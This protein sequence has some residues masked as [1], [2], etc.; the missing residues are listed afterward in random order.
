MRG[1]IYKDFSVFCKCMDKKMIAVAVGFTV[2]LMFSTGKYGGLIASILFAMLTGIQN[3]MSIAGDDKVHW[4]KY[5]MT[6]PLSGFSVVASKYI[7]VICT[8]GISLLGS[9]ILNLL[10]GVVSRSFD[11]SVW[12]L[13][14]FTAVFVPLMWT[15]ISLPFAY[16]FGAQSAQ[17]MGI[18]IVIPIFCLV[19]YFENGSGFSVMTSTLSSY[20]GLAGVI[21]VLVFGISMAVSVMG[22]ARRK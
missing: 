7:S 22:Y 4:K 14:I 10:S 19:R 21:T 20:F 3:V 8:L 11:A 2:L 18:V 16:W 5:Q 9:M 13:S 17:V 1:L 6:M 12:G 15:G